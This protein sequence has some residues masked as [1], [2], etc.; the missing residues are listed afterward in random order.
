[1][2]SFCG[3][4][5]FPQSTNVAFCSQCG[6]RQ[7][8]MSSPP[9][10]AV[11]SVPVVPAPM[12]VAKSGSGLKILL[13]VVAV[14]GLMGLVVIGG[15]YY[16]VHKVKQAVVQKAQDLGVDLPAATSVINSSSRPAHLKKPC[17]YLSKQQAADLLGEPIDRVEIESASCLYY[18]PAGLS[19]KLAQNQASNT[20]QRAQQ[21]GSTV[22]GN[23][24]ATSVDQMASTLNQATGQT[25]GGAEMPLLILGID[26]D[27]KAQM[28]ALNASSAIFGGIFKAAEANGPKG[29]TFQETIPGLG[30]RAI[31]LPKMGLNVLQGEILV[32]VIT[33]PIPDAK[34]KTIEIARAVLKKL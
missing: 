18:G 5:G 6:A 22:S 13:V 14:L 28:A 9:P 3:N 34:A 33:G 30:D 23:D 32:R 25:G 8:P 15:V 1:M 2:A 4:C 26:A 24:I 7:S 16:A 19:S 27:G 12:P 11:A 31:R 29:M 17:D 21:P 20:F 10:A